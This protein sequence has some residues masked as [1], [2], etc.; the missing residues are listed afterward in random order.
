MVSTG[1]FTENPQPAGP[2]AGKAPAG[3]KKPFAKRSI[4]PASALDEK[5]ARRAAHAFEQQQR[6]RDEERL[7]AQAAETKDR[8]R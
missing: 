7:K 4:P 8:E 2:A 6:Q 5:D 3:A 1:P